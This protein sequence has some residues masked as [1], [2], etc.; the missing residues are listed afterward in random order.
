[1]EVLAS[2]FDYNEQYKEK[3]KIKKSDGF[4][5]VLNGN[6]DQKCN[7]CIRN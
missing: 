1:M 6:I 4:R 5:G 7:K 2:T 3:I